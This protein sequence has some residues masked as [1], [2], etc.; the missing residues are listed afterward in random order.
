MP[1][2]S[3]IVPVY[4]VENKLSRC[5]DSI[6]NQTFNDFELLLVDN[7]S[8][9]KSGKICDEYAKKDSRITVIHQS[10]TG[11]ATARNIGMQVAKGEYGMLVD[12]STEGLYNGICAFL[13]DSSLLS[14]Y[15]EK[16]KQRKQFFDG[17]YI[18]SKI[19]SLF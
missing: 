2:I 18:L 13:S 9:D 3:V 19:E 6:L 10:N 7:G 11:A 16:A 15:Y 1:K 5:I 4:N 8:P 17:D 14:A 12:N